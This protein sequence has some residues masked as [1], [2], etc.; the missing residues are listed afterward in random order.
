MNRIDEAPAIL[1]ISHFNFALLTMPK[2]GIVCEGFLLWNCVSE[3]F[4]LMAAC[5]NYLECMPT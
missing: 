4:P 5:V 3:A 1:E 2:F